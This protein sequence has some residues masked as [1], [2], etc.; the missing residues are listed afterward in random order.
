VKHRYGLS[1][2]SAERDAMIRVLTS[3]PGAALP[4]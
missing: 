3:C 1:V 4:R 2:T